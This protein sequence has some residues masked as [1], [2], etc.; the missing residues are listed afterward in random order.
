MSL[1]EKFGFYPEGAGKSFRDFEQLGAV[2]EGVV[3]ADSLVLDAL[4]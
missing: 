2:G 3:G 1:G 4:S